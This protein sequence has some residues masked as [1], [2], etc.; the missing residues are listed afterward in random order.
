MTLSTTESEYVADAT[1]AK[2]LC[3]LRKL[4][5]DIRGQYDKSCTTLFVDNQSAIK[6]AK[7]PEFH[8]RTKHIDIRYHYFREKCESGELKLEYVSSECQKA[9]ILTKALPRDRFARM[10]EIIGLLN[11]P[12]IA[13]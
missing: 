13:E 1:A 7:S 3:W 5:C 4:M 6:L 10:R 2:E 8:K 12:L 11:V 9:D